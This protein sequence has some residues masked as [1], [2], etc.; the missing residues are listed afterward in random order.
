MLDGNDEM[1]GVAGST[2]T[3]LCGDLEALPNG[4]EE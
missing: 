4:T 1:I 3:E 2:L